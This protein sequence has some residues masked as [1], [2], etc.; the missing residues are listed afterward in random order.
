MGRYMMTLYRHGI[1]YCEIYHADCG[2][3]IN[4]YLI[5]AGYYYTGVVTLKWTLHVLLVHEIQHVLVML[6]L[7]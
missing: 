4:N 7:R 2:Y 3:N 5:L 6:S 1:Y